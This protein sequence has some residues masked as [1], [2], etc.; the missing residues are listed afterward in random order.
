MMTAQLPRARDGIDAALAAIAGVIGDRLSR[1]AAVREQHG[2]DLTWNPGAPP[3]AV[4][5]VASTEEVRQIVRI[6]GRHGTPIIPFGTGTS[7]EGAYHRAAGRRHASI[8][9]GMNRILEVNARRSRLPV[10]AGVTREQLNAHLRD[11]GLFFPIDPGADASLG[12]MAATRASGTNAV[13]YGTM[14]ENVLGL[15]VVTADG[16][17]SPPARRAR[18]SSA[19]YDL[20]RLFV[21]SEGT[22]G[23]ITEVTLRLYGIPRGDLGRHLP[24]PHHRGRLQ[25]R[26]RDHPVRHPRGP[27][28]AGGCEHDAAPST[29]IPSSICRERRRC[30]SSFTA[31]RPASARAGGDVRD[32]R[33]A[34]MAAARF[35]W[36]T[37]EEDRAEALA[38]PARCLLGG[39]GAAPRRS[40][41]LPPTSACRYPAWPNAWSRPRPTSP[42]TAFI[43]PIVGHVGRRQFP[44]RAVLSTARTRT[45][46]ARVEA[47]YER[48]IH[49][50]HRHGRHLHGR[51]RRRAGQ[52]EIPE[53]RARPRRRSDAQRSSSRSI[54]GTS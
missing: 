10:E 6:C 14:R 51:A 37:S 21:G 15:T 9:R 5:F 38:G 12:G 44:R 1:A 35:E 29:P 47:F 43:A 17:S 27:H 30:S 11:Q 28:R 16:E 46:M 19:G 23:V 24:V 22:L 50:G 18:K 8:C 25:Q 49:A 2:K 33:R 52:D 40:R 32:D 26:H 41:L 39:A 48:L 54:P 36:A 42:R 7:L 13:R 45:E 34:T 4:A 53:A 20:T 3:D 31:R